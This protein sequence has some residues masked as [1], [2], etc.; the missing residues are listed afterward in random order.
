MSVMWI[1]AHTTIP[2]GPVRDSASGTRRPAGAKMIAACSGAG[3]GSVEAPAHTQPRLR[4][5]ACFC[6]SPGDVNA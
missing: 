5:N 1:P 4:A 2:P 3:G 6:A